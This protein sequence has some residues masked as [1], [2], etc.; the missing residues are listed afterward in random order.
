M[1]RVYTGER[2]EPGWQMTKTGARGARQKASKAETPPRTFALTVK[3]D[4]AMYGRLTA[5]R[6]RDGRSHQDILRSALEEYLQRA[7][8]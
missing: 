3:V 6:G 5:L 2:K 4:Q 1:G 8:V 7:K